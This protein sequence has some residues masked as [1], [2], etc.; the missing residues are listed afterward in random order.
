MDNRIYIDGLRFLPFDAYY[1][2]YRK[3]FDMAGLNRDDVTAIGEVYGI[4]DYPCMPQDIKSVIAKTI[5]QGFH[6]V[7][8][9]V[10]V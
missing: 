1:D 7:K 6:E 2:L 3:D 10:R 9:R 4:Y 5:G 8:G